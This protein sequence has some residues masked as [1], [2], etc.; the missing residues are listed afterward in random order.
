MLIKTIQIA[1]EKMEKQ[2]CKLSQLD[3]SEFKKLPDHVIK[4]LEDE[5]YL[6]RPFAYEFYHQIRKLIEE[7]KADF[8]GPIIQAEVPK[9]YQRCFKKGKGKIPDFILHIPKSDVNFAVIEI[10]LATNRYKLE[11]DFCKLLDFKG[12]PALTYDHLIEI[13]IG[14]DKELESIKKRIET[15]Q[16]PKGELINIIS[17]NTDSW[18]AG[19]SQIYYFNN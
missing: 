18:S 5:K 19:S 6:E 3:Y 17:F 11:D 4:N 10:K 2:Y 15:I 7:G 14:N 9:E 1:L 8:G 16:K 12:N 13:I